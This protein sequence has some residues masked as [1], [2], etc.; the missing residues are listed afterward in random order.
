MDHSQG[1]SDQ[2]HA[3]CM[4]GDIR[5][6]ISQMT[7]QIRIQLPGQR[8]GSSINPPN[9]P[10][11]AG[12]R[13]SM[14]NA[15]GLL[16][17]ANNMAGLPNV[18]PRANVPTSRNNMAGLPNINP[19]PTGRNM[20]APNPQ[21]GVPMP[22]DNNDNN[23]NQR[24]KRRRGE[25][26]PGSMR[27]GIIINPA[28]NDPQPAN[29]APAPPRRG[30]VQLQGADT[31]VADIARLRTLLSEKQ[32]D[33]SI[34]HITSMGD[35]YRFERAYRK[36][37]ST[38]ADL[39][40]VYDFPDDPQEQLGLARRLVAAM[41]NLTDIEDTATIRDGKDSA[42]VHCVK[43]KKPIE[44]QM[45]AWKFLRAIFK[46]QLNDLNLPAKF[47]TSRGYY[48]TYMERFRDVEEGLAANK[49]LVRSAFETDLWIDRIA[50][51]PRFE[52]TL[53]MQNERGNKLQHSKLKYA[54]KV[55]RE[56][57]DLD[58]VADAE[59]SAAPAP[60]AAPAAP[61][62][63]GPQIQPFH[64]QLYAAPV[65]A[66]PGIPM[67]Y[68]LPS[69]APMGY[70]LPSTAPM[71][72]ALPST[73][74]LGYALPST[75]PLANSAN[76]LSSKAQGKQPARY[77]APVLPSL[78]PQLE[79]SFCAEPL[80]SNTGTV[81]NAGEP[82]PS[83]TSGDNDE[84]EWTMQAYDADEQWDNNNA[85]PDNGGPSRQPASESFASSTNPDW[86][87]DDDWMEF[88]E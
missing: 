47:S 7:E 78:G 50:D 87:G 3:S 8:V 12:R 23:M 74:P 37:D 36:L 34:D 56:N 13:A 16:P 20:Q 35:L 31:L 32:P 42:A 39:S 38:N 76:N 21:R 86:E 4:T 48:D 33:A 19:G 30:A 58:F 66:W 49:L 15:Q 51:R 18:N 68:A 65:N 27:P 52:R 44:M 54:S 73:A 11:P 2:G 22:N 10:R 57:P 17:I 40:S 71:G 45:C 29:F 82:G 64:P 75:A 43:T 1:H 25:T 63:P 77:P 61:A 55:Q 70:A 81:I 59:S 84:I 79:L 80:G 72:Y 14:G 28:V 53:K 85:T 46:A 26:M 41:S 5:T 67:G 6:R 24:N 60:P 69:T 83:N 88:L 9:N 62:V